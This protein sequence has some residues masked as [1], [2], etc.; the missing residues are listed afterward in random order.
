MSI[1]LETLAKAPSMISVIMKKVRKFSCV[2]SCF[3]CLT[4][5]AKDLSDSPDPS[6]STSPM[7]GLPPAV[8]SQN[9]D[10]GKEENGAGAAPLPTA[11]TTSIDSL[12]RP[13]FLI[14]MGDDISFNSFGCANPDGF[15]K[16]PNIDTL[17]KQGMRLT[18]FHCSSA[19]CTPV[20]HEL[21]TGLLPPSSGVFDKS[22]KPFGKFK[23]VFTHLSEL[24]Y[25]VGLAGKT[26]FPSR[27]PIKHI[28]G[29]AG[30]S[31]DPKPASDITGVKKFVTT[32]AAEKKNFCVFLCSVNAHHPW[33]MGDKSHFP[34]NAIKLPPH[35]VDTP[36]T[37]E[38]MSEHLAE[39]EVFDEQVG[40]ATR[41]LKEVNLDSNTIVIV[42]SE[43]GMSL[44]QGKWSIYEFGC[45]ALC[46]IR[47]PGHIPAGVTT[48]AV[49]M[50]CDILP[51][52]I[53]IA[54][55][56]QPEGIDGKSLKGVL[57][58]ET[59]EHRKYAFLV[60]NQYQRAIV[61]GR[62]KLVW[63]PSEDDFKSPSTSNTHNSNFAAAWGEWLEAAKK[64]PEAKKKV[65][66]VVKHTLYELYDL[67]DDP[68]EMV[69]LA[70]NPKYAET[71]KTMTEDLKLEIKNLK[72]SMNKSSAKAFGE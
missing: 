18:N 3:A 66:R 30:L 51:T 24:G 54:G 8:S 26:D 37:R 39:V 71:L 28:P 15:T 32:A 34:V 19:V 43:Q 9:K 40:E 1:T 67:Q 7:V 21:Y 11:S 35:M 41:M 72:D 29:Y 53:D 58:R 60:K 12:Q 16:T 65:D 70:K 13:N 10:G 69:D 46:V 2:I 22:E 33:T 14:V 31:N 38:V 68:F 62:Y 47:W 59:S 48:P 36:K 49:A 17:A 57:N 64:D 61:G 5:T 25:A 45:R 56:K 42:L 50:Y 6:P 44:P 23:N 63:T 4:L 55:G 52:L 27:Y 20:R